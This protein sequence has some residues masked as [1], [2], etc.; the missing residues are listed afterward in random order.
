MKK[1]SAIFKLLLGCGVTLLAT[2]AYGVGLLD[3]DL[4]SGVYM[5]QVELHGQATI[6]SITAKVTRGVNPAGTNGS[7]GAFSEFTEVSPDRTITLDFNNPGTQVGDNSYTFGD[8]GAVYSWNSGGRTGILNNQWAPSGAYG[9]VNTSDYLG[10]FQGNDVT[11]NLRD[12][13]N[14]FGIDWGALS[15][16]NNFSFYS[17]DQLISTFLYEDINPTAPV[18]AAQHGGEGNAYLHFYANEAQGTF[19]KIVITQAAGG[20]FETDNHSI[21]YSESAF[22]FTAGEDVPFEVE[23]TLG[24]MLLGLGWVGHRFMMK[25][26]LKRSATA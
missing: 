24:L 11:I 13:L 8:N 9:E 14:Y 3:E 15:S 17:D 25:S 12:D 16:G 4:Q 20:G 2:P 21:R 10:V 26:K 1:R 6:G 19:N 7:L 18:Q 5:N 22:D 23:S